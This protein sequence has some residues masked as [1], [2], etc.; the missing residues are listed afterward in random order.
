M[1]QEKVGILNDIIE[2]LDKTGICQNHIAK[3]VEMQNKLKKRELIISVIGQFKRG[4]STFINAIL[5]KEILPVGIVPITSV[6]TKIQ[7]GGNPRSSVL[8]ENGSKEEI[9]SD[10][11][12][13]YI[14]EQENPNNQK[15]VLF[16][17]LYLPCDLLKD[18][19]VIVDTPGVGSVHQHNTETAYSFVKESDAVVFMLSVD[20]PINEIEREFLFTAKKYASKFY[21]A[22]NKIDTISQLEL[23][24][25]LRYCNEFL[26]K[27]MEVESLDLFPISARKTAGIEEILKAIRQDARTSRDDI[28]VKSVGIKLG[29]TLN[30]ALSQIR[31]Y[32]SALSMPFKNLEDKRKELDD[33]LESLKNITKDIS[34]RL[35][36]NS[37]EFIERIRISFENQSQT[38]LEEM[39]GLLWNVFEKNKHRNP[40]Q[41]GE[42][43]KMVLE[44]DLEQCLEE[45]SEAGLTSLKWEYENMISL[46]NGRIDELKAYLKEVIF[47]L[48]GIEYYYEKTTHTLSQ[49]EDFYVSVN[50]VSGNFFID[51]RDYVYL[52]PRGY[53]NKIIYERY[54]KKLEE[55][56]N[57]N[58]T[59]IIYNYKYKIRESLRTFN[60]YIMAETETLIHSI[61]NL[62][63]RVIREKENV[64]LDLEEKLKA[65]NEIINQLNQISEKFNQD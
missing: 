18:G 13:Q 37:N 19:L 43:L 63:A 14:S 22:V 8:F 52:L 38:I 44:K 36:Q 17:N 31:L 50:R 4:K 32:Q 15:K 57:R 21:F 49:S 39:T 65:L 45:L 59:N 40:R 25:Y 5:N 24:A 27:T 23:E 20:S 41:L 28:L 56:V 10:S 46:L 55:D 58:L 42:E 26:C 51:I 62:I 60:S 64:H 1:N 12:V 35:E 48:F 7:Y 53:G 6:V 3:I 9:P 47:T 2:I 29:D 16:V 54:L 33:R 30:E 61:N 34:T 11:L